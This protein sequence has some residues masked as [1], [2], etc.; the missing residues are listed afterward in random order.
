MFNFNDTKTKRIISAVI[1]IFIV[2][3][4]LAGV[5]ASALA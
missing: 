3:A 1:V 5:I 2:L 4:M